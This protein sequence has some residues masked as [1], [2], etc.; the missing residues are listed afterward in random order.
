MNKQVFSTPID[1]GQITVTD[2]FW[3]REMELVRTEVIPYQWEALNDRVPGAD[4]SWCMRNFR[5][6]GR[7][8]AEQREKGAAYVTPKY[9]TLG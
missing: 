5:I 9:T 7:M 2:P 8:M 6:A 4:P 3:K 1:L